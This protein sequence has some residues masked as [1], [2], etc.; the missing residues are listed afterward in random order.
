MAQIERKN[1]TAVSCAGQSTEEI[2]MLRTIF[3]TASKGDEGINMPHIQRIFFLSRVSDLTM[4]ITSI[5]DYKRHL[6]HG[7]ITV[8]S[9]FAGKLGLIVFS[10]YWLFKNRQ[11]IKNAIVITEPTVVGIAGFLAKHFSDIKWVVDVW[12]IPI[13]HHSKKNNLTKLRIIFTRFLMKLSYRKADL[14]IVGIRPEFQ[15]KYYQV[16]EEKIL[17][18]QTTIWIPKSTGD[19]FGK[20]GDEHFNILCMKSLHTPACGLDILL[21]AFSKVKKNI[22]NARLWIIGEIPEDV[23]KTIKDLGKL[24]EVEYFGFIE[25][26]QVLRLIKEADLCVIPW[27][28]DVDLAQLYPTKVMEYMTEGKVV[29][30]SGVAGISEMIKDGRN[31][32]LF[33]PGD[34]EELSNKIIS[35][36]KDE[37]LRHQLAAN[38]RTYNPKFDTIRQHEEIFRSFQKLVNDYSIIDVNLTD[39]RFLF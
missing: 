13:R 20:R 22:L 9:P 19:N 16:P 11:N 17:A 31:G 35:L 7:T 12:D 32:V 8:R 23:E 30:A 4:I 28:D 24:E 38:A 18:W 14:F 3:L 27:H 6:T 29:V 39:E 25:H 37:T 10:A 1:K 21:Q 26:S 5:A 34:S 33:R 2:D 36:Y 15:F